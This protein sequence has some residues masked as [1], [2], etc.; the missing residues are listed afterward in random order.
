MATATKS[1][2]LSHEEH[3]IVDANDDSQYHLHLTP[4]G[5]L[6]VDAINM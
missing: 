2:A 5:L 1:G 4:E 6:A 3:I